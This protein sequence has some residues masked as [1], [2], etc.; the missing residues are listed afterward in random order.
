MRPPYIAYWLNQGNL[1]CPRSKEVLSYSTLTPNCLVRELISR[2]CG[3]RGIAVPESRQ[4]ISGKTIDE[5]INYLNSLLRKMSSPLSDRKEAAKELMRL[6]KASPSNR[7]AFGQIPNAFSRLLRP[8]SESKIELHP[9]L[10]EDLIRTVL[11][12]ST[13]DSNKA[14]MGENP[15][16]IPLLI[17]SVK[18]GTIETIINATAALY[19][20]TQLDSNKLIIGKSR[21]HVTL[22]ELL[23]SGHP[24]AMREA[25]LTI[26][27]L[28]TV[29]E[30]KIRFIEI[31]ALPVI[32]QMINDSMLVDELLGIFAQLS[33]YS[34]AIEQFREIYMVPCLFRIMRYSYSGSTKEN[35]VVILFIVCSKN[36]AFLRELCIEET[37]NRTLAELEDTGIERAKRKAFDLI[38]AMRRA[39]PSLRITT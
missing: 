27:N 4:N 6:T 18:C 21:A 8:L 11:N 3:V 19:T 16:V 12:L 20:L 1:T 25:A 29:H 30:N 10:Q 36:E 24:L 5:D 17:E 32:L 23:R 34:N 31:G 28:C 26:S 37:N 13:D 14:E 7:T 38:L 22:L 39:L 35:C 2:W 33:A 9:D 15:V